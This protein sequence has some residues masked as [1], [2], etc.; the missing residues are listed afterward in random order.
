MT[1]T[2]RRNYPIAK[3]GS[4]LI[5]PKDDGVY[6][7]IWK[8]GRW[9]TK[10]NVELSKWCNFSSQEGKTAF[11]DIG[12]NFGANSL[13]ISNLTNFQVDFILVEPLKINVKSLRENLIEMSEVREIRIESFA[14]SEQTGTAQIYTQKNHFGN[15]SLYL[16]EKNETISEIVETRSSLDFFIDLDRKYQFLVIKIDTQGSEPI[17][18]SSIPDNIWDKIVALT[19]EVEPRVD[20]EPEKILQ[21]VKCLGKFE[22]IFWD[23]SKKIVNLKDVTDFWLLGSGSRNLMCSKIPNSSLKK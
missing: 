4:K 17:I 18:L 7:Q 8:T 12:A 16:D 10:L 1:L 2:S 9:E 6:Y 19:L 5:A 15:T 21:V 20:Q 22:N 11:I 14:L 3:K 23:E 13:Q